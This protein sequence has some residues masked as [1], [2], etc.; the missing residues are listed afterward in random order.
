MGQ[1]NI[2]KRRPNLKKKGFLQSLHSR[3]EEKKNLKKK[4]IVSGRLINLKFNPSSYPSENARF[5]LNH[6]P[7]TILQI[8]KQYHE[9][10]NHY[11]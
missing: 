6:K 5:K 2:R 3:E 4:N 9:N 1:E 10:E 7:K 8:P 11:G